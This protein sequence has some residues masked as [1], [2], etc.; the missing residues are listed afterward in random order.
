MA[1]IYKKVPLYK[2]V[3][4]WED[5]NPNL[6]EVYKLQSNNTCN[7]SWAEIH[8][9]NGKY[10]IEFTIDKTIPEFNKGTEKCNLN[11]TNS[12]AEFESVLQ[13]HHK[14][15]WKQVLHEHFPE[16]VDA[17]VPVP[18][19][20]DRNQ[21][22]TFHQ[23][24]Q[25]FIQWTLNK[26][27]PRD[28]QY[29]YLQPGGDYVFQKPMMQ[30]PVEDLWRFEEMIQMAEALPAGDM[31]PP[32]QGL[33]LEWFYMFFHQEDRAKYV[34]SGWRL[35][36]EM[37]KS[38]TEYF[39]NIYNS[40]VADGSLHK[41]HKRQIEQ[42]IRRDM[43]H[44]L[45]KRFDE[46]VRHATEWR[47]GGDNHRNRRPERFQRPNFKW[48][49]R[50]NSNRCDTYNK[51]D[52]KKDDKIPAERNK[53]AFKP[54]LVHGPKSKHTSEE[55][56]KNPRN[57]KRQSYDRKRLHEAHHNDAHYMSKDDESRSGTD[58][59]APSEY[60]ASASSGS[61]E[62]EDENYHL[63]ASKRMKASGHVPRKSDYPR[64]QR[65]PQTVRKEKKGEKSPTF[66]DD[67]LDFTD[68]ILIGLESIDDAGDDITNPF[69]FSK[70]WFAPVEPLGIE[71]KGTLATV[72]YKMSTNIELQTRNEL[73]SL[74]AMDFYGTISSGKSTGNSPKK[75]STQPV[76]HIVTDEVYTNLE[77]SSAEEAM[78]V[79]S[80]KNSMK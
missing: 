3:K 70:W 2:I 74:K 54:C 5:N 56:Y 66:L 76:Y 62:Q 35:I 77:Q 69:D 38:L 7:K 20:Q 36:E 58:A 43:R 1:S 9:D 53:K 80:N 13:G 71:N 39:K 55:C 19:E 12:F 75:F 23:A 11:W 32:N 65:E 34:E 15:A 28:R 41:K 30:T 52:K 49:D 33:Q 79:K 48:Q 21:E 57:A 63:Q 47:Y 51:R 26:K 17:T 42:H 45:R 61:K 40:Q 46:K 31:H 24:I 68:A 73:S 18:A 4:T 29:I 8:K 37:L 16:P 60:P 78:D 10:G 6:S 22:G 44:E 64:Q 14:T 25:H 72:L 50:G 59:P 67:D 27:N